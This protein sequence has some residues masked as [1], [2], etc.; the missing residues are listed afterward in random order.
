MRH[1]DA[2]RTQK[3]IKSYFILL[4]ALLLCFGVIV[5][6]FI[7]NKTNESKDIITIGTVGGLLFVLLA[8]LLL[9]AIN[10]GLSVLVKSLVRD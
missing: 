6:V 7:L 10:Y 3:G 1:P 4:L 9:L 2:K 5:M 8:S